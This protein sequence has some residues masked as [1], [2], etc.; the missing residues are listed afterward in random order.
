MRSRK[1][2]EGEVLFREMPYRDWLLAELLLDIRDLVNM[3]KVG[4][5]IFMLKI[6][7]DEEKD[8]E[9]PDRKP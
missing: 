1:E 4:P 2:I 3:E 9:E 6:R 8:S 7:P 5:A